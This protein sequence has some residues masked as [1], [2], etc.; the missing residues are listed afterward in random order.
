M[1]R[2]PLFGAGVFDVWAT[3]SAWS[4]VLGQDRSGKVER[5]ADQDPSGWALTCDMLHGAGGI[6]PGRRRRTELPGC[7]RRGLGAERVR[8]TGNR[9]RV[10]RPGATQDWAQEVVKIAQTRQA[11]VIER[12]EETEKIANDKEGTDE[13]DPKTSENEGNSPMR[14]RKRSKPN[15]KEIFSCLLRSS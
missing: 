11:S 9:D 2:P 1:T 3:N 10:Q 8:L 6:G 5:A 14:I 15:L 13:V 12:I 7:P 4:G